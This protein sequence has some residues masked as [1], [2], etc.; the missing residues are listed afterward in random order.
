MAEYQ[1]FQLI[2][3]IY[4]R[5]LVPI[6]GSSTL[7]ILRGAGFFGD[8]GHTQCRAI[9]RRWWRPRAQANH[10]STQLIKIIICLN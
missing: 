2:P 3:L 6:D 9:E 8:C 5:G 1:Y 7:G 10:A 4:Y